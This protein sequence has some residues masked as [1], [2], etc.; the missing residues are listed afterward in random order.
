MMLL[1][2]L[3][4]RILIDYYCTV[5]AGNL[6]RFARSMVL[7]FVCSNSVSQKPWFRLC[8]SLSCLPTPALPLTLLFTMLE[9]PKE[10]SSSSGFYMAKERGDKIANQVSLDA[11]KKP[12]V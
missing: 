3:F 5:G 7:D 2:V 1:L 10:F 11:P 9:T 8:R 4:L 6:W 12:C